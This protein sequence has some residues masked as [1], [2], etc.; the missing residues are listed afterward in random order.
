[1][2]M[3]TLLLLTGGA[4]ATGQHSNLAQGSVNDL[5]PLC[6]RLFRFMLLLA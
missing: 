2:S 3:S 6:P 1:M 4:G 5:Q